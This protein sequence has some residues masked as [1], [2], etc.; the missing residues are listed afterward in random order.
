MYKALY[1][2]PDPTPTIELAVS[3]RSR[4]GTLENE[5]SKLVKEIESFSAEFSSL[6]NQ[7]IT[8]RK[9]EEKLASMDSSV[10]DLVQ[11]Q[12]EKMGEEIKNNYSV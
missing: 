9:L 5:N 2:A 8:I 1:E 10:E 11:A 4:I 7:D 12:V 6:K 3:L